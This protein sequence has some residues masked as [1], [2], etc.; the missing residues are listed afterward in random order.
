[1]KYY[2]KMTNT[3][4][5]TTRY[6]RYKCIDGF[7][8]N[9]SLCWKFSKQ[10]AIKIIDRLKQEYYRNINNVIFELEEVQE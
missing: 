7:T 4:F 1:M 5:G 2:I 8:E 3:Q 6:K 9:K 10:G